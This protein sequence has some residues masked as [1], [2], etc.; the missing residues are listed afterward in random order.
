[1]KKQ[2]QSMGEATY[3][4]NRTG[5]KKQTWCPLGGI[6]PNENSVFSW[7]KKSI[8]SHLWVISH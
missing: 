8:Y 7:V 1:M 5:K 3:L 4:I 2:K 6:F